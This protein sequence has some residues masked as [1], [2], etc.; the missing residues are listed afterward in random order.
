MN[1]LEAAS[2]KDL[3]INLGDRPFLWANKP[4]SVS[5]ATATTA[6]FGIWICAH[7]WIC[8]SA[9]LV[10]RARLGAPTI[11]PPAVE[12]MTKYMSSDVGLGARSAAHGCGVD[13]YGRIKPSGGRPRLRDPDRPKT[14]RSSAPSRKEAITDTQIRHNAPVSP[15]FAIGSFHRTNQFTNQVCP[16]DTNLAHIQVG[17]TLSFKGVVSYI[18]CAIF[19]FK[20][21]GFLTLFFLLTALGEVLRHRSCLAVHSFEPTYS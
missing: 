13:N 6:A 5:K 8:P 3:Y 2:A 14:P 19:C 4:D 1:R 17:F 9:G 12:S 7:R 10:V 11:K 18:R 21:S 16:P 20:V 15:P